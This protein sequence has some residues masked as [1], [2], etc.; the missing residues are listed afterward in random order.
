MRAA[1]VLAT[2]LFGCL[3]LSTAHGAQLMTRTLKD[4][5]AVVLTAFGTSTKAQVTYDAL[6]VEVRKSFPDNEL[7]W[8]FTSEVIRER[9]NARWA[10]EG[11]PDR[12]QSLQQALADL[13]AQGYTRVAVQPLHIFP[14]EEYEEVLGIVRQFPGLAIE[15]GETLLQRWEVLRGIVSVLAKDFLPPEEGCNV[16]VAHGTPMTHVGSNITYLGLERYLTRRFPNAFLGAVEGVITREDTL[17]AVR[18]YPV[19]R[20]RFIP[21]MYVAGDHILNDILGEEKNPEEPSWRSEVEAAGF[22]VDVP[23][24]DHDGKTLYRGL[25]FLPEV[26][27]VF[28]REIG[29]CLERL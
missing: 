29:R 9:V 3:L 21:L 11:K 14:G 1:R 24:I 2:A 10:K 28:L 18:A 22:A 7:R 19:K 13:E 20:V 6:E 16:V 23:T 17:D 8:A 25:G 27:E 4:R 26:N 5:P 12:L 15:T